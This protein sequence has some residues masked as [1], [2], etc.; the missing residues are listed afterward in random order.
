M[1]LCARR[2]IMF[3]VTQG[4]LH[5]ECRKLGREPRSARDN[6]SYSAH[7]FHWFM[8]NFLCTWTRIETVISLHISTRFVSLYINIV[9]LD[10]DFTRFTCLFRKPCTPLELGSKR[11]FSTILFTV[12]VI[13]RKTFSYHLVRSDFKPTE[14]WTICDSSATYVCGFRVR[15][16]VL[17]KQFLTR[18]RRG[19]IARFP[20]NWD[21]WRQRSPV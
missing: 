6:P 11:R 21:F 14:R 4:W 9:V 18:L 1:C 12:L 7:W 16:R 20:D 10:V 5:N 13:R 19:R 2:R 17:S 3:R 15:T 8:I